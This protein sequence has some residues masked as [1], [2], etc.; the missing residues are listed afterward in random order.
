M[1]IDLSKRIPE[2][3]ALLNIDGEVLDYAG[4]KPESE[5]LKIAMNLAMLIASS[6]CCSNYKYIELK[7]ESRDIV[8]IL[9]LPLIKVASFKRTVEKQ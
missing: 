5:L 3:V 1:G 4:S 2:S 7:A 6:K 8:I 9:E